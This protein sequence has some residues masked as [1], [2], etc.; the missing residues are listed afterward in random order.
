[1][2][3]E[4][5]V[6]EGC[7]RGRRNVRGDG[8]LNESL[9]RVCLDDDSVLGELLLNENDLLRPLDDKVPSRV[10]RALGHGRELG[11]TLPRKDA[12]VAPEHDR[13]S[14]N[15]DPLA[16]DLLLPASVFD[17]D[18]DGRRVAQIA[19]PTL[20]R[21]D[22]LVDGV[23]VGSFGR[24]DADVEVFE[25]EVGVDVRGDAGVRAE[26]RLEV[27][28]DK[29]VERVDVLLDESLDGEEG[30]EEVPFVLRAR[31][32]LAELSLPLENQDLRRRS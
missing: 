20:V 2:T 9:L 32:V 23:L 22:A 3:C 28:V 6:S 12:L 13:Q 30:G 19:Q 11:L 31:S 16:D 10:E 17:V 18:V 7:A 24:A 5:G 21:R 26:D 4:G 14:S 8:C 25:V 15:L 29:V 27:D 1:M